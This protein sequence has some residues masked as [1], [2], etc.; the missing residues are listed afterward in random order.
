MR[1]AWVTDPHLDYANQPELIEALADECA[2]RADAVLV[3]GDITDGGPAGE[4]GAPFTRFQQRCGKPVYFV[5]GNHDMYCNSIAEA[6]R[7]TRV[8]TRKRKGFVYLTGHAP[9]ELSPTVALVGDD[10]WYDGRIGTVDTSKFDMRDFTDVVDLRSAMLA[11][12]WAANMI[13]QEKLKELGDRAVARLRP[14]L[15]AAVRKYEHVV[16]ATHVPPFH[17][18]SWF[19]GQP[20]LPNFAPF[21]VNAGL[22]DMLCEVAAEHEDRQIFVFAGHAHSYREYEILPNLRGFTGW[23]CYGEPTINKILDADEL[24]VYVES[25]LPDT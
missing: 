11:N 1:L 13:L 5:L 12:R 23:A 21:Y 17:T 18:G 7:K 3:T 20:Q 16:V 6:E 9:I 10:G 2:K 15:L 19:K 24:G 14:K 22:G 8:F 25:V 4:R